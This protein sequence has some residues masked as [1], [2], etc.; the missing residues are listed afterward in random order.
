[1]WKLLDEKVHEQEKM[2]AK[3]D[4]AGVQEDEG[5]Q[6]GV[7]SRDGV[8]GAARGE[9]GASLD[10]V[11]DVAGAADGYIAWSRG[12]EEGGMVG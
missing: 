3:W 12:G 2:L 10:R 6:S 4:N 9:F 1:M 11:D 7:L 8:D 5:P